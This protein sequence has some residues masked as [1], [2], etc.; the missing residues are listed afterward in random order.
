MSDAKKGKYDIDELVKSLLLERQSDLPDV[1]ETADEEETD[2]PSQLLGLDELDEAVVEAAE[3][4]IR[5]EEETFDS[6]VI[7]VEE[8]SPMVEEKPQEEPVAQP[9]PLVD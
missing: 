8:E 7:E 6:R 1:P 2:E 9:A 3:E 4:E 5:Q